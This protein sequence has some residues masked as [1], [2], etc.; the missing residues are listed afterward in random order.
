MKIVIKLNV[1]N[2]ERVEGY[3]LVVYVNHLRKRKQ[4]VIGYSKVNH[5]HE[6]MQ[7][8]TEDH[9]DYDE[10]LPRLMEIKLKAR[11]IIA[12]GCEDVNQALDQLLKTELKVIMFHLTNT[13]K[14][15]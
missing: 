9:P 2:G 5:F 4:K 8:V 6:Q 14:I 13:A 15:I 12:S 10:L 7:L 3:E 1:S 11:K